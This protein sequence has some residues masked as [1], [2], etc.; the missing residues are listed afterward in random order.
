MR[1]YVQ[2]S[3]CKKNQKK[4]GNEQRRVKIGL[5]NLLYF[6]ILVKRETQHTWLMV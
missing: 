2:Y 1:K 4:K 5:D 6:C 3:S